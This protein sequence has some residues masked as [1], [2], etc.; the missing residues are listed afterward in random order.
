VDSREGCNRRDVSAESAPPTT[1]PVATSGGLPEPVVDSSLDSNR[2]AKRAN[3][4]APPRA[5]TLISAL[6]RTLAIKVPL[7]TDQKVGG[8]SNPVVRSSPAT[9]VQS[10]LRG[11]LSL[12]G[13]AEGTPCAGLHRV[14][15]SVSVG[16]PARR[17]V[18]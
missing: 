8:G 1:R 10:I 7:A 4:H 3:F 6:A 12:S 2:V 13:P 15:P 11:P 5:E 9:P 16:A 14:E 17:R 18:D